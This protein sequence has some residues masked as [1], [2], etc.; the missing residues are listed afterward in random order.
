MEINIRDLILDSLE[1]A[2]YTIE[3][4]QEG[5]IYV[6][7]EDIDKLVAIHIQVTN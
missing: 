5:I 2:G 6:E 7:D 1:N 4:T 3:L